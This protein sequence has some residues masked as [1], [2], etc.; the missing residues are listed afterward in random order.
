MRGSPATAAAHLHVPVRTLRRAFAG[1]DESFSV[2]VRRRRLE[3]AARALAASG[4]RLSVSEAAARRHLTDSSHFIRA[5]E[6]RYGTTPARFA[7]RPA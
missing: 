1:A 3:E 4:A 5:F 7:R 2:Y 6:K